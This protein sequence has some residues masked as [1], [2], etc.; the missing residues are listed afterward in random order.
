MGNLVIHYILILFLPTLASS[1]FATCN[2]VPRLSFINFHH[3]TPTARTRLCKELR[4]K[5]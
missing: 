4:F 5:G 3:P 2:V 1:Y